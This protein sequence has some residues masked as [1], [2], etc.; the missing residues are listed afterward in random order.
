MIFWNL[1]NADQHDINLL[2]LTYDD[3]NK[4][5]GINYHS[6]LHLVCDLQI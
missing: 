1:S 6:L 2:Y 3:D 5:Y 4:Y